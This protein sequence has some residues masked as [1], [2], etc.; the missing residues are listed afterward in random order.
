MPAKRKKR[1]TPPVPTPM[2]E[3]FIEARKAIEYS[4]DEVMADT[5]VHRTCLSS[6]ETRGVVPSLETASILA[7]FYEVPLDWLATGRN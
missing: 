1:R 5:G 3:R 7:D 4:Q 6:Y 2:G